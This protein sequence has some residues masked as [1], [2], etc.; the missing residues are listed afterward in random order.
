[1]PSSDPQL[2]VE[3]RGDGLVAL[4]ASLR[5]ARL[6][7]RVRLVS[8]DPRWR[9]GSR[10]PLAAELPPVLELPSAW[11][12]LFSKSG[13]AM[14]AEL[15]GL[16]L[17]LVEAPAAVHVLDGVALEL[18]TERAAQLSAVRRAFGD[19]AAGSWRAVLDRADGLW[20]ARRRLGVERPVTEPPRFSALPEAVTAHDGLVQGGRDLPPLLA[21]VLSSLGPRS[22]GAPAGTGAWLLSADLAVDRVFGRWQLLGAEGPADLQPLLDLLDARL[23]R[24][25]VE[26]LSEAGAAG[27]SGDGPDAVVD[28]PAPQPGRH[29]F[30]REPIFLAPT[31]TLE[32][33]AVLD[34]AGGVRERVDH[35][36]GGPVVSWRWRRGDRLVTVT[37]D[38]SRPV[39]DPSL[40]AALAGTRAWAQRPP[41]AWA[42]RDGVATLS[43]SAASH[44][45]PEP[46]AQLLTGA[47]AAYRV[48]LRLTGEDVSPTNRAVGADGRAHRRRAGG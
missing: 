47:L 24:R 28:T 6:G 13:R 33:V 31:R 15:A 32:S 34:G 43:A 16:G 19:P 44:G 7:H 1:M 21:A 9:A 30:R 22:G 3:V 17:R 11:K 45:G 25:G 26:V 2:R 48:H 23:D 8:A 5:L 38:H 39:P 42:E 10:R 41:L 18:P 27:G 14:D 29:R 35:R 12:D 20:Q 4:A 36:P 46:W 40:G 37:H